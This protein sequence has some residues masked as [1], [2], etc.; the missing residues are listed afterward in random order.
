MPTYQ[1]EHKRDMYKDMAAKQHLVMRMARSRRAFACDA[2]DEETVE[3]YC[4]RML[5][6]LGLT[7]KGDPVAALTMFLHGHEHGAQSSA[8]GGR[9]AG[10]DASGDDVVSRYIRGETA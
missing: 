8:G 9:S 6:E 2:L 4:A 1:Q 7:A 5:K 10:M 3:D